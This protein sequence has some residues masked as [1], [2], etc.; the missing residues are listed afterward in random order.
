[1]VPH[2]IAE[3]IDQKNIGCHWSSSVFFVRQPTGHW[4]SCQ[5][6]VCHWSPS[7]AK[8]DKGQGQP[9]FFWSIIFPIASLI[10]HPYHG[11]SYEVYEAFKRP[12][13][14]RRHDFMA[15]TRNSAMRL[16]GPNIDCGSVGRMAALRIN[17][18]ML[19]IWYNQHCFL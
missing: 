6:G 14:E 16:V 12:S 15:Y 19:L 18:L 17:F 4:F 5:I 9:M 8:T 11:V 3:M 10:F 2:S 1:M 13:V 7:V